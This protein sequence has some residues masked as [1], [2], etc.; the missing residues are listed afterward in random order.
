[1]SCIFDINVTM[2]LSY[3]ISSSTLFGQNNGYYIHTNSY[4]HYT[5]TDIYIYTS[6]TEDNNTIVT[7]CCSHIIFQKSF[8]VSF[9][10]LCVAINVELFL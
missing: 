4:T 3:I 6:S 10:G 8:S 9:S 5:L 1:M 7:L 2:I